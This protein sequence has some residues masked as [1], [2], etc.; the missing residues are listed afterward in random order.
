VLSVKENAEVKA[1][2]YLAEGRL[3]VEHVD[4]H[5]IRAICRGTGEI[6]ELGYERGRW[7]CTCPAFGRCAHLYALMLVT[8]RPK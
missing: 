8:R 6:Y 4:G 1:R 3:Q 5:S 2:R 7:A